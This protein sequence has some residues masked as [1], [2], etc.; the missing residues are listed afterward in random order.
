MSNEHELCHHN[1][2]LDQRNVTEY[3]GVPSSAT[4]FRVWVLRYHVV[5]MSDQPAD[6]EQML[7]LTM[8]S[9]DVAFSERGT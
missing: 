5:S 1:T 4:S 2:G 3:L 7:L 6:Q 8:Y 9:A